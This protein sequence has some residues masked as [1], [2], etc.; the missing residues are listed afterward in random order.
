LQPVRGGHAVHCGL[1]AGPFELSWVDGSFRSLA[2]RLNCSSAK[3]R[4]ETV[5]HVLRQ[6][7]GGVS[8]T[9]FEL[10]RLRPVSAQ[11]ELSLLNSGSRGGGDHIAACHPESR[12]IL[13][14]RFQDGKRT[15]PDFFRLAARFE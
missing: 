1:L 13:V 11:F 15:P 12:R 8:W 9:I 3:Q 14:G 2:H 4:R 7:S 10:F 5:N 6:D